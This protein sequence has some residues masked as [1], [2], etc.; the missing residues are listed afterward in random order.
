MD[1]K[2]RLNQAGCPFID[3]LFNPEKFPFFV[4]KLFCRRRDDTNFI[5]KAFLNFKSVSGLPLACS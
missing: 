2:T 5:G 1:P 3:K 4:A